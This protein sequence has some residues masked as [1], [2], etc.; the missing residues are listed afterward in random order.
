[1]LNRPIFVG[2]M[3][4]SGTTVV[5]RGLLNR[6]PEIACTIPAEMWFLTDAGGLCDVANPRR[7]RA[8]WTSQVDLVV[9]HRRWNRVDHFCD[10]MRTFWWSRSWWKEGEQ[11]G[12]F[13]S[14]KPEQLEEALS[15][16]R[17]NYHRDSIAAARQLA[18]DLLDPS[19]VARGKLRW[20]DTTPRNVVRADRLIRVFP[21]LQM[22]NMIRDGRDVAS[23]LVARPWGSNDFDEALR[24]WFRRMREGHAALGALPAGQAITVDLARLVRTDRKQEYERILEF[25][26]VDD[27]PRMR[28]FFRRRMNADEAHMGRWS[29]RMSAQQAARVTSV[30]QDM[31]VQLQSKGVTVPIASDS[32]E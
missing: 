10:R 11:R 31:V 14:V 25:L 12:L 13:Q 5:G 26:D 2:G 20:V 19:A 28:R 16:F 8:W 24:L 30:Y 6:H 1:M 3:S 18:S 7:D 21:D 15:D 29:A 17:T 22:I 9:R 27:D 23:S 4:R 32:L